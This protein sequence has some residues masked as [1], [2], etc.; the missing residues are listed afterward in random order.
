[1]IVLKS[2]WNSLSVI[3]NVPEINL[4]LGLRKSGSY[5]KRDI[6]YKIWNN[7]SKE[8]ILNTN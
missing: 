5:A 1:M 8:I 4:Q 6:A 2:I 3:K 7:F